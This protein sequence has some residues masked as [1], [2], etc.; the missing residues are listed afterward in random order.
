MPGFVSIRRSCRNWLVDGAREDSGASSAHRGCVAPGGRS[1][2][3]LRATRSRDK[4]KADLRTNTAAEETKDVQQ[5]ESVAHAVTIAERVSFRFPEEEID[6]RVYAQ[7]IA[8][9]EKGKLGEEKSYSES[10]AGSVRNS[11]ANEL[12][13]AVYEE[14]AED[15]SFTHSDAERNPESVT[16]SGRG[17][18]KS[19]I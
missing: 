6:G 2:L 16:Q 19:N 13:L 11:D 14:Q 3:E 15:K 5:K 1:A 9:E 7:P 10:D 17:S 12:A 18:S 4:D 8:H